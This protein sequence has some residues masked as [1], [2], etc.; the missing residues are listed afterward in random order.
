MYLFVMAC[1]PLSFLF[2]ETLALMA[3]K[4]LSFYAEARSHKSRK[5]VTNSRKKLQK[6]IKIYKQV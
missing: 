4:I 5:I 1:E 3:V 2:T 6:I